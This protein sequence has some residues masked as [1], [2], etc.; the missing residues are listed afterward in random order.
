[1]GAVFRTKNGNPQLV[2]QQVIGKSATRIARSVAVSGAG[3]REPNAPQRPGTGNDGAPAENVESPF[4][5]HSMTATGNRACLWPLA[6]NQGTVGPGPADDG[7]PGS[8][9]CVQVEVGGEHA[10]PSRWGVCRDRAATDDN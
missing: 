6:E 8:V 5:S 3:T 7:N 9:V 2:C 10:S 4:P 1:V